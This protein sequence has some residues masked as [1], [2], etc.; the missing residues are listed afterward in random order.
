[1]EAGRKGSYPQ[2]QEASALSRHLGGQVCTAALPGRI[3]KSACRPSSQIERNQIS[4]L[5]FHR[6]IMKLEEGLMIS[7]YL[8]SALVIVALGSGVAV[9]QSATRTDATASAA[10]HREGEWRASKLVGVDV[11]NEG[12]QKIG[13]ISEI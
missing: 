10:A 2:Q 12:N 7:K 4:P 9:A 5:R 3:G 8:G 11:Y 6:R 1:M 13:D